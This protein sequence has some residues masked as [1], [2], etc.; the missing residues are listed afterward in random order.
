MRHV[1][2]HWDA[3][4]KRR[5]FPSVPGYMLRFTRDALIQYLYCTEYGGRIYGLYTFV[6][7]NLLPSVFCLCVFVCAGDRYM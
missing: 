5:L 1:E 3:T 6:P 2:L 4:V 7:F